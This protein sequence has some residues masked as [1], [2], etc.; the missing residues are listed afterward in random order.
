MWF[1]KHLNWTY[2]F[3]IVGI[4]IILCLQNQSELKAEAE[5][6]AEEIAQDNLKTEAAKRAGKPGKDNLKATSWQ[7]RER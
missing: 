5:K 1:K 4:I 3:G 2:V 6:R 7:Q